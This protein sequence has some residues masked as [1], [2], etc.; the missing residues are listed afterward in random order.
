[1]TRLE[2]VSYRGWPH[3]LKLSNGPLEMIITLDVGPRIIRLG[4]EG[5]PNLFHEFPEQAGQRSGTEWM[6]FGGHRLWHAP[7][8]YP[9]TYAPDFDPV[10]YQWKDDVLTLTSRAEP[11]TGLSKK[12]VV[13]FDRGRVH[14]RHHLINHNPWTIEVAPWCLSVMTPGGVAV[15]PQ[16]DYFPHP[17]VLRPA[18]PLI[19]W[20]FTKMNDPR[21]VWGDSFIQLHG[22]RQAVGKQKF[23]VT[24]TKGWAAYFVDGHLFMKSVAFQKEARYPDLGRNCEF[25]TEPDFLEVETLGPLT[26]LEP[27]GEAVHEEF[28]RVWNDLPPLPP[29]DPALGK[30][31]A[32]LVSDFL[33]G[34]KHA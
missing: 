33:A 24:N 25:Y 3:C 5:K 1:M 18:R 30:F 27:E 29:D 6:S 19:L 11:S 15:V 23:G 28:W 2:E 13:S 22:D 31:M 17:D 4:I 9:R 12:I 21:F 26:K 16:E 32:P 10:E 20:H 34:G 14:L 7:E 8:V